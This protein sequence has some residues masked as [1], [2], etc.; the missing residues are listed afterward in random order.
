MK[1]L[2]FIL[3]AITMLLA[4]NPIYVTYDYDTAADF[5]KFRT[6]QYFADI[7]TG[8]NELDTKRLLNAVDSTLYAKGL[9][10]SNNPDVLIDIKSIE[11]L[12]PQR[13]TIGLGVGGTGGNLGGGLT[14]GLPVGQPRTARHITFEFINAN[15]K[16]LFW[17][18]K[19]E[20]G[21]ST[22]AAPVTRERRLQD[23]VAKVFKKYPV[24]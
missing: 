21:F 13:E 22:N 5:S 9:S 3:L 20:A 19:S 2:S 18:A 4:C 7:N 10:I 1:R 24:E 23:I 14:I 8:L 17:Q 16:Q 6:Y 11:Y 12:N 15:N